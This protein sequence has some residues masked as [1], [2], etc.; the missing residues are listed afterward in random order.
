MAKTSAR[1]TRR[2]PTEAEK[3]TRAAE[4]TAFKEAVEAFEAAT[5]EDALAGVTTRFPQYSDKN[6]ILIHLQ[7]PAATDVKA[8]RAWQAEGRQ[9][10]KGEHGIRIWA[11]AGKAEDETAADGKVTKAGRQFF[12]LVSVFDVTQTEDAAV[13]AAQADAAQA[14]ARA[15]AAAAAFG[16]MVAA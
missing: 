4:I 7:A 15:L 8:Y 6:N 16:D 9:V 13:L 2:Q 11:P 3:A 10:R 14:D 5:D 1:K 12:R